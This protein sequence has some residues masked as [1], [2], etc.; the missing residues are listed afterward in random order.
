M[1]RIVVYK[2]L[3]VVPDGNPRDGGTSGQTCSCTETGKRYLAYSITCLA[4]A[5]GWDFLAAENWKKVTGMKW[6]L[7]HPRDAVI[8]LEASLYNAVVKEGEMVNAL[9]MPGEIDGHNRPLSEEEKEWH[10]GMLAQ[11]ILPPS[12]RVGYNDGGGS[13]ALDVRNN[14]ETKAAIEGD[15]VSLLQPPPFEGSEM[16]L[17]GGYG[18]TVR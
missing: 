1:I 9:R 16:R 18:S 14:Y 2:F 17:S 7:Y 13:V 6:L 12:E 11:A 8:P 4:S 15:E 10:L 5:I 3:G